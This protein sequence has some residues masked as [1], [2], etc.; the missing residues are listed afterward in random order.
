M[1]A[2]LHKSLMMA[3]ALI[4]AAGGVSGGPLTGAASADSVLDERS[5]AHPNSLVDAREQ[6]ILARAE[7]APVSAVLPHHDLARTSG[8]E[9]AAVTVA[10]DPVTRAPVTPRARG[11]PHE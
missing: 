4:A 11:P 2:A 10:G 1:R 7:A 6:A 8:E 5:G 9:S 3:T